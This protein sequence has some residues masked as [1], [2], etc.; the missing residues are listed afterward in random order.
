MALLGAAFFLTDLRGAQESSPPQ[1][2]KVAISIEPGDT[3]KIVVYREPDLSGDFVVDTGGS[4]SYPLV[5]SFPVASRSVK[6]IRE[7][8]LVAIKKFIIDPQLTVTH[9]KKKREA[10]VG[11]QIAPAESV[12]VLGEVRNPGAHEAVKNLTL[13]KVIAQAGGVTPAAETNKIKLIRLIGEQQKVQLYSMDAIN[14]AETEDPLVQ[15]GDKIIVSPQKKDVNTA[16]IL[17]EVKSAGMY[18]VTPDFTLM[19]LIAKAGG[20]TPVAAASK[21]RVVRQE[22]GQKKIFVYNAGAII[23]GQDDDPEIKAGDMVFVPESFF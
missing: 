3:L 10:S 5:G 18:E 11:E 2:E 19:K 1:E 4:I 9:Q 16:A 13:T 17:G 22:G 23:G 15:P 8:L 20:F 7:E 14:N 21:V 12:T 6:E